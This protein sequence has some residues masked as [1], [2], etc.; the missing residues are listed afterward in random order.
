M[1]KTILLLAT[2]LFL[3]GCGNNATSSNSESQAS[4]ITSEVSKSSSKEEKTSFD[5]V[6]PTNFKYNYTWTTYQGDSAI[7]LIRLGDEY[8]YEDPLNFNFAKMNGDKWNHYH[9]SSSDQEWKDRGEKK[10]SSFVRLFLG[11][12]YPDT[13]VPFT[14]LG[15]ESVTI[16][17]KSYETSVYYEPVLEITV[18]YI[19]TDDLK[20][21]V[22]R[23]DSSNKV[24]ITAFDDTV[25]K[26]PIDVPDK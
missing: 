7:S 13:S 19:D 26:F 6:I 15:T 14:K 11:G 17:G 16:S 25:T 5:F 8:L 18:K 10:Y 2:T 1:K 9:R 22:D 20:L 23:E 24:K 12:L 4:S 3:V 21:V